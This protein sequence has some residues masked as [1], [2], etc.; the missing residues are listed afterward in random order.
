M[1]PIP[2]SGEWYTSPDITPAQADDRWCFKEDG[3]FIYDN[4]GASFSSCQGYVEDPN[5]PIPP[6]NNWTLGEG[7][8]IDNLDRLNL[9]GIWMGVEDSGPT[10]DMIEVT[11]NKMMLLTPIRPCDGSP[12][13]G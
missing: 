8:G 2:Y 13:N 11:G 4:A 12:S 9:D 3:T 1:G 6:V 5:Y 7:K 10:Y